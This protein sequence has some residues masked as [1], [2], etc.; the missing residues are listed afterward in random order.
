MTDQLIN[1]N[2]S[3]KKGS[4]RSTGN[5]LRNTLDRLYQGAGLLAAFIL[6][7]MLVIIILQMASR[8]LGIQFPG[9]SDYAAYCMAASS[10]LA[11]AYTLKHN[12]HIRVSLILNCTHGMVRK[13]LDVWCLFI[14]SLLAGYLTYYAAHN[15]YLSHLIDDISQGQD[16][17]PLWIPQSAVLIGSAIFA[18]ALIDQLVQAIISACQNTQDDENQWEIK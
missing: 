1:S 12:A 18:V 17:T 16:A 3:S 2:L 6:F 13:L 9:S 8:W 11:L 5:V 14:A 10:F 15:V 4:A 7:I